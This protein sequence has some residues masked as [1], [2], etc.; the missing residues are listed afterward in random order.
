M[1]ITEVNQL[2]KHFFYIIFALVFSSVLMSCATDAVKSSGSDK[3]EQEKDENAGTLLLFTIK[4]PGTEF[5]QSRIFVN[6]KLPFSHRYPD[7][8]R[9]PPCLCRFQQNC[10]NVLPCSNAHSILG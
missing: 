5:Y 9:C 1:T 10:V 7:R 8:P 4:E 2:K 3:A 6:K